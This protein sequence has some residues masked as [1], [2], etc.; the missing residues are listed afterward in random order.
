M[1]HWNDAANPSSASQS[2]NSVG[3]SKKPLLHD[4]FG[5]GFIMTSVNRTAAIGSI[6]SLLNELFSKL[7]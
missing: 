2:K 7:K 6:R 4:P 5:L 3:T 1:V